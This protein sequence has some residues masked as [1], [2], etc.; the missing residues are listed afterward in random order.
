[1]AQDRIVRKPDLP[2]LVGVTE[3]TVREWEKEGR[4]PRR[5]TIS[6]NGHGRAVGWRLSEIEAWIAQQGQG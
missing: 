3:R 4:F 2:K 6:P 5:F 1:M